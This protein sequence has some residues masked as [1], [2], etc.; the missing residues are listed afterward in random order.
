M[1]ERKSALVAGGTGG[2]GEGI[3]RVLLKS[4]YRVFVPVREHDR[5]DQLVSYVEDIKTGELILVQGDL[6]DSQSV[7]TSKLEVQKTCSHL[8][9]VVA[10]VGSYH[11]YY[12]HSLHK[13]PRDSWDKLISENVITH[14]NLQHEYLDLLHDQNRG[15]YITLNGPE[16][17]IVHP[18]TG[19]MSI[20][21]STQKMMARVAAMEA[22]SSGVK[23]YSV[24]SNTPVSTRSRGGPSSD[25]WISAEELGHYIQALAEQRLPNSGE[26]QHELDSGNHLRKV[27]KKVWAHA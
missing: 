3:V 2:I 11:Y 25:E 24:T 10:S 21:A 4:D 1:A 6:I 20:V 13:I 7:H 18:E 15:V 16:A 23:V 19:L 5:S 22:F 26:V 12:G 14:F 27:L 17:N 8:D 9:L